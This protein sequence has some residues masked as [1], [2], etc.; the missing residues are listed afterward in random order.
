VIGICL[1]DTSN[2]TRIETDLGCTAALK[3]TSLKD[4]SNKTRI[5]TEQQVGVYTQ[6]PL[7]ERYFQ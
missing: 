5:E 1:K 7:S 2:K 4:T 3:K 6:R